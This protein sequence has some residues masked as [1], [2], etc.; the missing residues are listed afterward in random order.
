MPSWPYFPAVRYFLPHCGMARIELA[1]AL[2]IPA[3]Y[4]KH[5]HQARST[6][7]SQQCSHFYFPLEVYVG[8]GCIF[9]SMGLL[10]GFQR[11]K[12]IATNG[13]QWTSMQT[14]EHQQQQ[15]YKFSK[16]RGLNS[17][18]FS[19]NFQYCLQTCC[20]TIN[21]VVHVTPLHNHSWDSLQ[22]PSIPDCR[23]KKYMGT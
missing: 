20:S 19:R 9:W 16:R 11:L 8:S 12:P 23:G 17:T 14:E 1:V 6:A 7:S 5:W 18:I 3:T 21:K 15:Q 22:H 4:G 2:A 10:L 13:L